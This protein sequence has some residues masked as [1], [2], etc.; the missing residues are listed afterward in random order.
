MIHHC[1]PY[2]ACDHCKQKILS[3]KDYWTG[4]T[5]PSQH[6]QGNIWMKCYIIYISDET[7]PHLSTVS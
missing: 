1:R 7:I 2:I 5:S 6:A 4:E 3:F